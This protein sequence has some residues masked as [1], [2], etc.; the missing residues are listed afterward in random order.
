MLVDEKDAENW[1][2]S[3]AGSKL[4]GGYVDP[5][6]AKV[7]F[8]DRFELWFA[9]TVNLRPT[10]R[11]RDESYAK[12]LLLPTFA[13]VPLGAIDHDAVQG[14]VARLLADGY[15]PATVHRAHQIM[16]KVMRSAV[17]AR[18]IGQNPCDDTELPRI[19]ARNSGS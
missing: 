10:T 2:T 18:L 6:G 9:T 13:T 14:W 1:L 4:S 19:D 7:R 15:A 17:K 11:A 5:K 8:G 12:S 16:S 3:V